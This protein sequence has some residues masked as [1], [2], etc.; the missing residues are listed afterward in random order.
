[1]QGTVQT[2]PRWG[3][4]GTTMAEH[5]EHWVSRKEGLGQLNFNLWCCSWLLELP[6]VRGNAIALAL[7][8]PTAWWLKAKSLPWSNTGFCRDSLGALSASLLCPGE[9]PG[10]ASTGPQLCS[11]LMR[12]ACTGA[13]IYLSKAVVFQLLHKELQ[14]HGWHIL[15]ELQ[16][17]GW[18]VA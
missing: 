14:D 11:F 5:L 9:L 12:P 2:T 4:R 3:M 7:G 1:M 16:D 10:I 8:S 18:K 15:K 17:H 6:P 13:C